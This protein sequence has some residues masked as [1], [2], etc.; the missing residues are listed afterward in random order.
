[1][2]QGQELEE[3]IPTHQWMRYRDIYMEGR[4]AGGV[5]K[6]KV[7]KAERDGGG[8]DWQIDIVQQIDRDIYYVD[9]M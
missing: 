4:R 1:V 9:N 6:T 8:C 2:E 3:E 5:G 7:E